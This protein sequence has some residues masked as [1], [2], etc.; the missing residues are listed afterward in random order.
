M[1]GCR[2]ESEYLKHQIYFIVLTKCSENSNSSVV[3]PICGLHSFPHSSMK[4][5]SSSAW[6]Q[7]M[8][9]VNEPSENQKMKKKYAEAG[10]SV[11]AFVTFPFYSHNRGKVRPRENSQKSKEGETYAHIKLPV[12]KVYCICWP[13]FNLEHFVGACQNAEQ[14]LHRK[15]KQFT[16]PWQPRTKGKER[17]GFGVKQDVEQW[18]MGAGLSRTVLHLHNTAWRDGL[19]NGLWEIRA[20]ETG[21]SVTHLFQ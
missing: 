15:S 18:L 9:E 21:F 1:A 19:T 4:A 5:T 3:F 2:L 6:L 20:G 16:Q 10:K 7:A 12:R 17:G 13:Q 14:M 11:W 8:Q